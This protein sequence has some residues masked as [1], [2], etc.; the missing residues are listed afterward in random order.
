MIL[1]HIP[2]DLPLRRSGKDFPHLTADGLIVLVLLLEDHTRRLLVTQGPEGI[3]QDLGHRQSV[4]SE[5]RFTMTIIGDADPHR[6][7]PHHLLLPLAL[8]QDVLL[9]QSI[10]IVSVLLVLELAPLR[11]RHLD[12]TIRAHHDLLSH[13]LDL[14]YDAKDLRQDSSRLLAATLIELAHHLLLVKTI[15]EMMKCLHRA[16]LHLVLEVIVMAATV[17][18]R[19]VDHHA[20]TVKPPKC[21]LQLAPRTRPCQCLHIIDPILQYCLLL[22]A[23]VVPL[24]VVLMDLLET[25]LLHHPDEAGMEAHPQGRQVMTY[26]MD[27][28]RAQEVA[29][30][31]EATDAAM[32]DMEGEILDMDGVTLVIHLTDQVSDAKTVHLP[33][34]HT[35]TALARPI[36]APSASTQHRS[37]WLVWRRLF[38]EV[39]WHLVV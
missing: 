2:V 3:E 28:I 8:R 6:R 11:S 37:T 25:S 36:R 5:E 20:A 29:S 14:P 39:N 22:L 17:V 19:Q 4:T 15:A 30:V 18:H 31:V 24:L 33:S 26:E 10:L 35:T 9:H 13:D 7:E 12:R 23:H 27:L 38:P 1:H 16:S 21:R 32:V 34:D